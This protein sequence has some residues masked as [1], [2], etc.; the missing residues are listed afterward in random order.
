VQSPAPPTAAPNRTSLSPDEEKR[1]RFWYKIQAHQNGL[2]PNPDAPEHKYDYRAAFKAGAKPDTSGHWPSQFKDPDHPNRY[3]IENGQRIDKITGKP[4]PISKA[5][6]AS[7]VD[8]AAH[9]AATSTLNSKS[10]PSAAQIEAGNY[11]KGQVRIA[12]LEISIE[13]PEG[14]KRKP[15]WPTLK[16][17]YGYIR[18]TEGSDKEPVDVFVKPG[19]AEDYDGPVYVVDQNKRNGSFD[20]HKVMLGFA[21]EKQAREAYLENY[22]KDWKGLGAIREFKIASEFRAWLESAD[23]T[24]RAAESNS[25]AA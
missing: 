14:S 15:E 13:N 5:A 17:H 8:T 7:P 20:E 25:R 12:G 21:D 11:P 1:F 23:T 9:E 22:T 2:D 3:V 16:Q 4:A 18:G 10:E 24:K 19:T 6:P